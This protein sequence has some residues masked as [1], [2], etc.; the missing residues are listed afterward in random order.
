MNDT[1]ETDDCRPCFLCRAGDAR[2]AVFRA[3]NLIGVDTSKAQSLI[4]LLSS[5]GW[6]LRKS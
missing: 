5:H 4:N 3:A 2:E 1:T 6:E